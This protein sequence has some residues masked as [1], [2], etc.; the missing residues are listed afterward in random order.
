MILNKKDR[1]LQ[2]GSG[3][4]LDMFL[5]GCIAGVNSL[6]GFPWLCAATVRSMTHVSALTVMSRTHAPGEKPKLLKVMEQRLTNICVNIFIG[7]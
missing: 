5:I 3:Y 1:K 2:K 6:F 7:E 4:H